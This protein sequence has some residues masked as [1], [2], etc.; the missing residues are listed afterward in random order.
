MQTFKQYLKE[1]APAWQESLSTMLFELPR[2]SIDDVVIPL[3]SSIIE[4]LW[5][6]KIRSTVFHLTDYEG[7]EGLKKMQNSKKSISAFFNMDSY[8][9]ENGIQTEGGYVVELSAD[10]L[11]SSPDD[12]ATMVDKSGRRYIIF[13]RLR[14]GYEGGGLGGGTKLAGMR[15]DITN[16][17]K[18]L[19]NQYDEWIEPE[20]IE[21]ALGIK[22][23][24]NGFD[25]AM[26]DFKKNPFLAWRVI[27]DSIRKASRSGFV[28]SMAIKEYLDVMEKIMKKNSRQLGSL[29]YDYAKNKTFR[30]EKGMDQ[31]PWDELVVNNFTINKIHVGPMFYDDFKD[32]T[33][34][35]GFPIMVWKESESLVRHIQKITKIKK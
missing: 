26:K 34:I 30:Y 35:E 16:M 31:S 20:D 33:E 32:K 5:P 13:Q 19:V 24:V 11:V 4:R 18:S 14:Q 8:S 7:I 25:K 2:Q 28:F 3:G 17:F 6:D 22:I 1:R 21:N 23:E 10:I 27:G 29:F 15:R 9:I 12:L